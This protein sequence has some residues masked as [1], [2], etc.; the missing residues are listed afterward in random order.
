MTMKQDDLFLGK[1]LTKE[2]FLDHEWF[3][4]FPNFSKIL[5]VPR[6]PGSQD[7]TF[8]TLCSDLNCPCYYQF[9]KLFQSVTSNWGVLSQF[10][11]K[12]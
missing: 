11:Y 10:N 5:K 9:P 4:N 3:L 2:T 7:R 6:N 8:L 12:K 1:V